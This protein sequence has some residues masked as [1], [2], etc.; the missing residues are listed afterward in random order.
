MI[1]AN[2]LFC[3]LNYLWQPLMR[4]WGKAGDSEIDILLISY[5]PMQ[6]NVSDL[7]VSWNSSKVFYQPSITYPLL[8]GNHEHKN[9]L[10]AVMIMITYCLI[11]R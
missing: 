10:K 11:F 3:G 8:I 9:I 2:I 5:V 6:E 7:S 1:R 4:F